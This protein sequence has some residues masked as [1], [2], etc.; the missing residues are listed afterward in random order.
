MSLKLSKLAREFELIGQDPVVVDSTDMPP[1]D[2]FDRWCEE[3]DHHLASSVSAQFVNP[4]TPGYDD[5]DSYG[6][7]QEVADYG[8]VWFPAGVAVGWVP[9]RFGHWAWIDPWGW[10]WIE[11]EPW[12]FCTFHFGRWVFIGSVWGWLPGPLFMAPVYAPAFVTFLG[13]P[14]F[15]I[16][17]GWDW[18]AGFP[19]AQASLFPRGITSGATIC[20]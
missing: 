12:G 16:G 13:G 3:R 17:S 6:S 18:W 2:D 11:D 15:D 8:P 20:A 14:G 4:S 19:W 1:P 9:Y 7:W 5:L 10:T